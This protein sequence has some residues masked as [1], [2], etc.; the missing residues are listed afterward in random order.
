MI[1]DRLIVNVALE[2]GKVVGGVEAKLP[3]AV[4]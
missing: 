1:N 2:N 3:P 4:K